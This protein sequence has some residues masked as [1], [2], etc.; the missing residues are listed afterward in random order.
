MLVV[1]CVGVREEGW[2]AMRTG[3]IRELSWGRVLPLVAPLLRPGATLEGGKMVVESAGPGAGGE[4]ESPL[5]KDCDPIAMPLSGELFPALD[6]GLE[7]AGIR[8]GEGWEGFTELW[9]A[10]PGL[11]VFPLLLGQ[12]GPLLLLELLLTKLGTGIWNGE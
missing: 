2:P 11:F 5:Q 6:E 10:C 4:T 8:V 12:R 3:L 1:L 7:V 9:S